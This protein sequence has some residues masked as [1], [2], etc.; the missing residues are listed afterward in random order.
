MGENI[1]NL[2]KVASDSRSRI[3]IIFTVAVL[4]FALIAGYMTFRA[5]GAAADAGSSMVSGVP[6]G[7]K[8]IPGSKDA[9]PQYVKLQTEQNIQQADAALKSG[10]TY[11]PTIIGQDQIG[12]G[13]LVQQTDGGG[14]GFATLAQQESGG[15]T[16]NIWADNL[17]KANCN[18]ASI[19]QAQVSGMSI[20]DISK[21]CQCDKLIAANIPF[22]QVATVCSC[23]ALRKL[24]VS[25]TE[26]TKN[27]FSISQLR[28][29]GYCVCELRKLGYTA[30][31]L[32]DGGFSDEQLR[33]GCYDENEISAVMGVPDSMS[34]DVIR[35]A[36]C[37]VPA[38]QKL[39][40]QG[41]SASAIRRI[42]GCSLEAL[43]AA[44]YTAAELRNA[45]FTAAEMKRAGF[46]AADLTSAGYAAA[47]TAPAFAPNK[48]YSC[49]VA[50]LKRAIA[51]GVSAST[52]RQQYGCTAAQ[53]R[54][55][56]FSAKQLKDAG[57]TAAEL[58]NAG[59]SAAD[60]KN[61][62]F[63]ARQLRDAGF[64][65]AD[66]K[67][68]GF[69]AGQLKDAGFSAKDLKAA[70]YSAADLKNAGFS[71]KDLQAAGY[72]AQDLKNAGFSAAD[73]KDA[74]FSAAALKAAGFSAGDLKNA[75]F[76][77]TELK[78]AGYSAR[79]MK[80]AGLGVRELAE[81]GFSPDALSKAGFV[82]TQL[83]AAGIMPPAAVI[84]GGAAVEG[85]DA[86]SAAIRAAL[87]RQQQQQNQQQVAQELQ[88]IQT[89]MRGAASNLLTQWGTT[90]S[91][92]YV[93]GIPPK[94]ASSANGSASTETTTTSTTNT[95]SANQTANG[96]AIKA[97]TITYAVMETAAN[98]D[99]PGPVIARIVAGDLAGAKLIGTMTVSVNASKGTVQFTQ[100]SLPHVPT[101]ISVN[102]F[103]IDPRTARTA[104]ASRV[105]NH[106]ML[107]YGSMFASSFLEG[108]GQ[109]VQQ[110]G[111]TISA[112]GTSTSVQNQ[113]LS[114]LQNAVV[115]LGKVGQAW[116]AAVAPYF[117]T[118]ATIYVFS[119]TDIGILF[120]SD[121]SLPVGALDRQQSSNTQI[122]RGM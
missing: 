120:T 15:M 2:T 103:A 66:L 93:D 77:P 12:G 1:K 113:S 42:T 63:S 26:F 50:D 4:S 41:V 105:D 78:N 101:T 29:C 44:G 3:L 108:V 31:Q 20:S 32:K 45:G 106:Y 46:S 8:A 35:K 57:F 122:V 47:A 22:Q 119:G 28:T 39:R 10:K 37:S 69:S 38:L 11:I 71:P 61:A 82:P 24:G 36:G 16:K 55:A 21:V 102:A 86:A 70:G 75:G 51:D 5:K 98:S 18:P 49:S 81:A 58:K 112:N 91:Q 40:Q 56:G 43:K 59:F 13:N 84:T 33:G 111:T 62:G 23:P 80:D 67:N 96:P 7:L 30:A 90:A 72:S 14:A 109:S 53:M 17:Q 9:T 92:A 94:D 74:G 100:L 64:S 107:R 104:I 76:S 83:R 114:T 85:Q 89:K 117:A 99:E 97:G 88:G 6:A 52:I 121:T 73:L 34:N 68:A 116:G 118:P 54:A 87:A 27:R 60:L 65:A 95:N 25:P 48:K 19:N 79:D 110:E 115:G